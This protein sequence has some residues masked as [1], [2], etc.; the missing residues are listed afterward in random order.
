MKPQLLVLVVVAALTAGLVALDY[1][2]GATRLEMSA[3]K[4][5]QPIVPN[6]SITTFSGETIEMQQLRGRYVLVNGWASWCPPCVKEMPDLLALAK[7]YPQRLTLVTLSADRS[8][9]AAISFLARYGEADAN[10]LHMFDAGQ[11]IARE[12]LQIYRYPE[13]ILVDPSGQ[14]V[15][16]YA[17]L[18]TP[19]D[20]TEIRTLVS[21]AE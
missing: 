15:R 8:Q 1:Q 7:A 9:E 14:M 20:V 21:A 4:T 6:F 11:A 3:S 19:E 17:G 12:T 2:H 5:T 18:L 10:M 16:K 13:S